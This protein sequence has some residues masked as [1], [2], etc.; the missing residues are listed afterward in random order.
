MNPTLERWVRVSPSR[1][2]P[3]CRRPDWC[4]VAGDRGAAICPRTESPRRCGEAGWLHRL[5]CDTPTRRR[6][7]MQ[8]A[9]FPLAGRDFG[10]LGARCHE[11][12][13]QMI[14]A[15]AEALGVAGVT[16]D[17]LEVGWHERLAC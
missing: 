9:A 8:V 4:L 16:L 5:D 3:I 11:T 1:P 7:A 14:P 6:P 15:L 13:R 17:L 2:C 12:G 10:R